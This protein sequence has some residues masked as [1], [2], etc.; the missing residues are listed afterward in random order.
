MPFDFSAP[1]TSAAALSAYRAACEAPDSADWRAVADALAEHF[2]KPRKV[3]E[4]PQDAGEWCEYT[5]AMHKG[6]GGA[7]EASRQA[8]IMFADGAVI[9]V[10]LGHKK[11]KPMPDWARACRCAV[12]FYRAKIMAR[13]R[14][15]FD[16]DMETSEAYAMAYAVPVIVLGVDLT[17]AA[18][19]SLTQANAATEALR[20]AVPCTIPGFGGEY[21]D[22]WARAA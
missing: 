11:G 8:E 16:L 9:R 19:V 14:R 15:G 7:F 6:K 5:P 12:H 22:P 3:K 21:I 1:I 2:P 13:M 10:Q 18:E 20:R 17:R 4:L